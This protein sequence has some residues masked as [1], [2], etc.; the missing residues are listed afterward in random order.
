MSGLSQ[1][2]KELFVSIQTASSCFKQL[3]NRL[4]LETPKTNC[5][6]DSMETYYWLQDNEEGKINWLLQWAISMLITCIR[7]GRKR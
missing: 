6:K 7:K 1:S 5:P 4:L 3:Q 2:S